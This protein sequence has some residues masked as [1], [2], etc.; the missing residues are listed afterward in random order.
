MRQKGQPCLIP[1]SFTLCYLL[2]WVA[3]ITIEIKCTIESNVYVVKQVCLTT[4]LIISM[5]LG[6]LL[7]IGN[8]GYYLLNK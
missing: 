2:R 4:Y 8:I 5:L 1:F 6:N 7:P 3:I